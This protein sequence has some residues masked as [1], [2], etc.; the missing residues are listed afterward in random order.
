MS[1]LCSG[2][3]R[4]R[5]RV[6]GWGLRGGTERAA[7]FDEDL[8][9]RHPWGCPGSQDTEIPEGSGRE[10]RAQRLSGFM[11]IAGPASV[12]RHAALC[13]VLNCFCDNLE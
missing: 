11:G 5:V 6:G 3:D 2:V 4:A 7:V 10:A 13:L 8:W 12:T 1:A 9:A